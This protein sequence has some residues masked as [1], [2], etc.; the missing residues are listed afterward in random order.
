M[1]RTERERRLLQ[2]EET[3]RKKRRACDDGCLY[4]P[5]CNEVGYLNKPDYSDDAEVER[6]GF[7][8]ELFSIMGL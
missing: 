3:I 1:I 8:A 7:P 2:L 4:K 6:F 5:Q